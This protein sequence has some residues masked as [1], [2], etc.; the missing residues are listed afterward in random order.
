[1]GTITQHQKLETISLELTH[2]CNLDCMHCVDY[3]HQKRANELS[4]QELKNLIPQ[5]KEMGIGYV[6]FTSGEPLLSPHFLNY[7]ELLRQMGFKLGVI[8]NGTLFTDSIINR[9]HT[10]GFEI[11]GI[12]IDGPEAI[13][14]TLRQ[15]PGIFQKAVAAIIKLKEKRMRV[16][17][18]TCINSLTINYVNH[19]K[20]ILVDLNIDEWQLICMVKQDK[21]RFKEIKCGEATWKKMD[22]LILNI[23]D[24]C[25][26]PFN[27][28][29]MNCLGVLK[30]SMKYS[31]MSQ[32]CVA[33]KTL[34]SISSDGK[35][36]GCLTQPEDYVIGNLREKTLKEIWIDF[37]KKKELFFIKN[38]CR[39]Y[40]NTIV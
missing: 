11:V 31:G 10:I 17:I 5:M 24:K 7:S 2:A 34:F 8:T 6:C 26:Y 40:C 16:S 1:M 9:M 3:P 14:D 39:G 15:K 22:Q 37:Q 27:L 36:L 28:R 12:S 20:N 25:N 4:W 23:R 18:S 13:H 21:V 35:V 29:V 30:K 19:L 38:Y 33:G 32:Q